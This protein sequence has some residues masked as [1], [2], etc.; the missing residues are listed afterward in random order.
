[1][2]TNSLL[3]VLFFASLFSCSSDPG[4]TGNAV[5]TKDSISAKENFAKG[6][7][8]EKVVNLTDASQ[9][10]AIYL[11]S[12]YSTDKTYP[13]IYIFDAHAEATLPLSM[14]KELAE[15]YGYILIGSNNSKN[16]LSW[17]ESLSIANKLFADAQQRISINTGRVYLLGFSGGARVANALCLSN[18]GIAGVICCGAA[19]PAINPKDPRSDYTFLGICGN[20]DFNYI[21]MRKYDMVGLAGRAVKRA[22]LEFDGG[23]E[24][25][26][27]EVMSDAFL[28]TELNAIRTKKAPANDSL[29][30]V[31]ISAMRKEISALQKEGE[32]YK[33]YNTVR[34]GINFFDGLTPLTEFYDIYNPLKSNAEVDKAL[35]REE[36]TW[37]KED[38]LKA[39]YRD[40]IQTK[41][42][43][44]WKQDIAS[45]NKKIKTGDP[46]EVRMQ[47]RVMSY[48]SLLA[49]MQTTSMMQKN[50]F[51]AAKMFNDIY[52]LVDPKNSEGYYL[53]A[54]IFAVQGKRKE[55]ITALNSAIDN[56]F[57]DV[58]RLRSD[59]TFGSQLT[60]EEFKAVVKRAGEVK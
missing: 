36:I 17:E 2:K 5:E 29:V 40:A 3:L 6:Q 51:G 12:S 39:Y 27:A 50:N 28:W 18:G 52:I 56:G 16:G 26:P 31:N 49:Y 46:N 11:P 7:I 57:K 30:A 35:K 34:R 15:K 42:S 8:I 22:V 20:K 25:P 10:A 13:V 48:L 47:Q 4:K 44:W 53:Q 37:K 55:V 41:N 38:E 32:A 23:H 21:E 24:W 54:Q 14:Y 59:N 43:D 60:D 19:S 9:S 33:V 45:L 1:M 58:T